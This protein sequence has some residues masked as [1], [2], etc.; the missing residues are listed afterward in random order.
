MKKK[1][2]C[3]MLTAC[4]MMTSLVACQSST[5]EATT[6]ETQAE[7]QAETETETQTLLSRDRTTYTEDITYETLARYPDQNIDSPVKF[8]GKIVQT[9]GPVDNEGLYAIRMSVDDNHSHVIIVTYYDSIID[10]KLLENDSITIYGGYVGEY[11][12]T[13]TLKKT[14]TL[15]WVQA[16][17]I[18]LNND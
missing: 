14:V 17:M 3:M 7:T 9:I 13:S 5:N 16:V 11:S 1:I 8:S 6:A 4:T 12:Y 2:L 10:G 18:D 15:P